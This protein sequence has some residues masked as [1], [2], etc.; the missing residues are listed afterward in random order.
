VHHRTYK[1]LNENISD[2]ITKT[3][4]IADWFTMQT[5]TRIHLVPYPIEEQ[6]DALLVKLILKPSEDSTSLDDTIF[7][8][9]FEAITAGA[10]YLLTIMLNKEWTDKESAMIYRAVFESEVIKARNKITSGY[11]HQTADRRHSSRGHF[12]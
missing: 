11:V 9:W 6:I 8:G 3:G 10:K 1:W 5:P 4:T 2:W 7:D 12:F